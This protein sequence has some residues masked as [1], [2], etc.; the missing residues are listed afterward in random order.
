MTTCCGT[1]GMTGRG[2]GQGTALR[3]DDTKGCIL[4]GGMKHE[5]VSERDRH[6]GLLCTR[7][8]AGCGLIRNDPVPTEPELDAFYASAYRESYKGASVPR[9]RQ[10]WRNFD[11][12]K[13]HMLTYRD[14]YGQGGR[15]LDLGS[16]SGEFLY[17]ARAMG[18]EVEGVEPHEGYCLYSR[19]TL[20]LPV[21]RA[22]LDSSGYDPGSFDL[23]RLSHVLE[24][25]RDPLRTLIQL[26]AW[27]RPGGVLYVE[28]PDI[29][30][31]AR[32][33]LRGRL[34]HYGHINNFDPVTLRALAGAAGLVELGRTKQRA[35]QTTGL[36]LTAGATLVPDAAALARNAVTMRAIMA[37]HA[38]ALLP[39]P[40]K[41]TVIGRFV[42][43]VHERL[44]EAVTASRFRCHRAIAED[45]AQSLQASLN[46]PLAA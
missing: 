16:G 37:D 38:K 25:M 41:G 30:E 32:N 45:A 43:R 19:D 36:F 18:A 28:V 24:H 33:R 42:G 27:L 22:T 35:A 40:P 13:R 44:R 4:C 26:R 20:G 1:G 12:T 6:G 21:R 5:L 7:L 29:A 14:V 2:T 23:I 34:F 11:R 8:C 15:W 39:R 9:R 3:G 17:L 31:E 10:V 46:A